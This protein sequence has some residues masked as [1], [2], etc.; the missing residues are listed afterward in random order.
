MIKTQS[1]TL[2]TNR[3]NSQ[4]FSCEI[5]YQPFLLLRIII[6]SYSTVLPTLRAHLH[7]GSRNQHFQL[8]QGLEFTVSFPVKRLEHLCRARE[9][10][11]LHVRTTSAKFSLLE[12]IHETVH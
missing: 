5:D 11:T 12:L 8:R 4:L 1:F 9:T 10:M 2:R 7:L 6:R 3:H